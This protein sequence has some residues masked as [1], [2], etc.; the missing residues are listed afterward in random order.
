MRNEVP[1]PLTNFVAEPP[2]YLSL[3]CCTGGAYACLVLHEEPMISRFSSPLL[4]SAD[5][6]GSGLRCTSETS[7]KALNI[8]QSLTIYALFSNLRSPG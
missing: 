2:A 8:D 5:A 4:A 1:K 7:S 6:S 3:R